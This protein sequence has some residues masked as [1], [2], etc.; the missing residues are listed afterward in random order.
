MKRSF[1]LFFVFVALI[2]I[3]LSQAVTVMAQDSIEVAVAT[4]SR[5]VVDREPVN[6]GSS[7]YS[8]VGR[9]YFFTKIIGAEGVNRI[10]H[11]WYFG[12]TERAS[13]SLSVRS[14]SWRT[15][16][17]KKIQAHEIGDWHVEVL[18]PDGDVLETVRFKITP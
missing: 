6:A 11:V 1:C 9:L 14:A 18:G 13:I 10:T 7:F 5:D 8:S 3:P 17:S 15:F 4:I 2:A 16:S 12:D